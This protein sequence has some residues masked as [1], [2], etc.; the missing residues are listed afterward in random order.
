MTQ[1]A[2]AGR[3]A[4]R[5]GQPA[6]DAGGVATAGQ[7]AARPAAVRPS[8][9]S[10]TF[11]ASPDRVGEARRYL[12]DVMAGSSAARD[13]Q[14]CL[15]EAATNAIVH[16]RSADRGGVFTVLVSRGADGWRVGVR[17]ADP[18]SDRRLHG[19]GDPGAGN[20]A[21]IAAARYLGQV[22]V[23]RRLPVCD[24]RRCA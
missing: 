10:R 22:P 19:A 16:S 9:W 5:P 3:T 15:S 12:A 7:A 20:R 1:S 13:A 11:P 2:P 17:I 8:A 4:L 18:V 23:A 6:A 21:G 14:V 24:H